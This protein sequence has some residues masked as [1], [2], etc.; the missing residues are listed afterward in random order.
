MDQFFYYTGLIF[1]ASIGL[2]LLSRLHKLL[3]SKS[4]YYS[5][6]I[7]IVRIPYLVFWASGLGEKGRKYFIENS[8]GTKRISKKIIVW[9]LSR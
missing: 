1:W 3:Y 4:F 8:T 5:E 2:I 7:D 6:L 9:Y